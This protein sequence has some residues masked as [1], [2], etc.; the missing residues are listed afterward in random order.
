TKILNP[1]EKQTIL[2]S[3]NKGEEIYPHIRLVI[4]GENGVGKTCLMRRLLKQSIEGVES[5]DGINIDV[6][7]CKIRLRDGKWIYKPI[8]YNK[9]IAERVKRALTDQNKQIKKNNLTSTSSNNVDSRNIEANFSSANER[10]L[11]ESN[12]QHDNDNGEDKSRV[13]QDEDPLVSDMMI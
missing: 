4:I 9:S 1:E 7:N 2:E 5:T 8:D 12:T 3:I 6:A 13:P 11:D 10:R